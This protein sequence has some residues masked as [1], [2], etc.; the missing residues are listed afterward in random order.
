M[1]CFG[2]KIEINSSTNLIS[3]TFKYESTT[4]KL[5][6]TIKVQ[7][8]CIASAM[9]SMIIINRVDFEIT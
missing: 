7:Q 9:K 4:T 5:V 2:F 3:T 8:K 6:V 1:T